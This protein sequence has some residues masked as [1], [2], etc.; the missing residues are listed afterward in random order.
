MDNRWCKVNNR[1]CGVDNWWC[2]RVFTIPVVDDI[3][4]VLAG[5]EVRPIGLVLG[6]K[7]LSAACGEGPGGRGVAEGD[8]SRGAGSGADG[9]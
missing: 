2:E 4:A 3:V 9:T 5:A 8:G 7:A 1:W 6:A